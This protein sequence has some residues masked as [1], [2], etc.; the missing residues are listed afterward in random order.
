MLCFTDG[1]YGLGG[2]PDSFSFD[3][4]DRDFRLCA[5]MA[6]Q[7]AMVSAKRLCEDTRA[8]NHGEGTH[9]MELYAWLYACFSSGCSDYLDR[10]WYCLFPVSCE[11][12]LRLKQLVGTQ[13]R[14]SN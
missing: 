10:A 11:A 1:L 6:I 9:E 7:L 8:N 4:R 5:N 14:N 12:V 3:L 13:A 2:L